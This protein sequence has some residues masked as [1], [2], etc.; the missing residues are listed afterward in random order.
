MVY[1]I[2][3]EQ[4]VVSI[5]KV[6]IIKTLIA[7][8]GVAEVLR[9]YLKQAHDAANSMKTGVASGNS[10]LSVK[11]LELLIDALAVAEVIVKDKDNRLTIDGLEKDL[12]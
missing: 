7:K 5:N 2:N 3:M 8:Y 12:K 4:I 10:L 11:D 6:D 9:Y 1:N